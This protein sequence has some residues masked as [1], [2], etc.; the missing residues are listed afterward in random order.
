[1][2]IQQ[3]EKLNFVSEYY[4]SLKLQEIAKLNT[5]GK[6]I[7]NL[8]IGSPDLMPSSNIINELNVSSLQ[9]NTHA[10]QSY[11]GADFLRKEIANFYKKTYDVELD[12]TSEVLPLMGSK[13]GIMHISMSFLNPADIV[14]V[15]N[16]GYPTYT[17]VSNL[18]GAQIRYYNLREDK[19]WDIDFD[20]LENSDLE[21]VKIMWINYPHMP[22]GATIDNES[23]IKLIELAKKH[24]FLIV[25]DNPYSLILNGKPKS[26]LAF[27][28]A[29]EVA[30]ELNSLSKSHNMAG[31]RIGWVSGASEYISTILK[32]KSNMDSGMF[33][34]LQKAAAEALANSD[35]LVEQNNKIY[36]QRRA[37]VF[38]IFDLLNCKYSQN[39][40]GLFIWAK[41]PENISSSEVLVNQLLQNAGVF[42]TP[43]FIFGSNGERFVRISLTSKPEVFEQAKVRIKNF[44]NKN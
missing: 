8:G 41:L 44:L 3:A 37:L 40:A 42:I 5:E 4:F 29:K 16:P 43:G 17:S 30:L 18:A 25:N 2:I 15:P 34:P 6:N 23:Y 11:K 24:H 21:K 12:F 10:Y 28:G 13:E 7:I 19:N 32:F 9:E 26:I 14:L 36:A 33:L 35:F 31:W 27:E 22:T 20:E 1:M 38:E 39:Q